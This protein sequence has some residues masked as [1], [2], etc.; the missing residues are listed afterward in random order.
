MPGSST[1]ASLDKAALQ[2]E[3]VAQLGE[4]LASAQRAHAAAVE[5]ATHT[6]ARA[7]NPKD[8]RGLEQ[9]YLARGQ[10][11]RV[12]EL[13]I[14][15]AAVAALALRTFAVG[16]PIAISALVTVDDDGE[17]KRLFLAPHGGGSVLAGGVQVVT[18]SSPLGR[19]L[20]GKRVDDEAEVRLPGGQRTLI[21]AAVA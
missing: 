20:L 9:S 6:E 15:V 12:A 16:D 21:V 2:A 13:E 14:G 4:A 18:P 1:D 11:Q 7:E 17:A 8:T 5:G 19:A 10:A 3:L